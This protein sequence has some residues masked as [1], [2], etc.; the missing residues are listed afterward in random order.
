MKSWNL[1]ILVLPQGL[2][3]MGLM[4]IKPILSLS[5]VSCD[6]IFAFEIIFD[7]ARFSIPDVCIELR[8]DVGKTEQPLVNLVLHEITIVY[9]VTKPFEADTQV[10]Y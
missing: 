5:L 1:P 7:A 6:S 9:Q 2:L 3:I 8:G 4:V 10:R